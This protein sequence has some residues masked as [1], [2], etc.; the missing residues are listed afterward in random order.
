MIQYIKKLIK[1]KD[2]ELI[3]Y[4]I[5]I[6]VATVLILAALL[7][8]YIG[9][10]NGDNFFA[11][12]YIQYFT[13]IYCPGCGGTRAFINLI[14]GNIL[15][16]MRY[17]I[18]VPYGIVVTLVFYISQTL[19][20]ITKGRIKGV[21]FYKWFLYGGIIALIISFVTKNCFHIID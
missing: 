20:F 6:V 12:C 10:Y 16:S 4:L 3:L 14:H 19:R 1:E 21:R 13:G 18:F 7:L 8:Y 9:K 5:G 2:F 17:N 15:Q 11:L